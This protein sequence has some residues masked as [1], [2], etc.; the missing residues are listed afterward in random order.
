MC[1]SII[2]SNTTNVLIMHFHF[3]FSLVDTYMQNCLLNISICCM[4]DDVT[5]LDLLSGLIQ[6]LNKHVVSKL[7][8]SVLLDA[9]HDL[10]FFIV[11]I[12]IT[13]LINHV[14]CFIEL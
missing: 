9:S 13:L 3:H 5:D 8:Q 12:P 2:T 7:M 6:T 11:S 10:A 14:L 4:S 1:N